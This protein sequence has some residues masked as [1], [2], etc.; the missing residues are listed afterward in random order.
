[1]I[2]LVAVGAAIRHLNIYMKKYKWLGT[3]ANLIEIGPTLYIR[4]NHLSL[5][6]SQR[7]HQIALVYVMF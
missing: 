7:T 2:H 1:M 4:L 3:L 6:Y 5:H